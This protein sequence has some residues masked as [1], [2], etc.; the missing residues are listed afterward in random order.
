MATFVLVHGSWHGAWCWRPLERHLRAA[1]HN[2]YAPTLSGCAERFDAADTG[3]TLQSHIGDVARFLFF[4]DLTDVVLV[5]HSSA[6]MI[7]PGVSDLEHA[8]ILSLV[9]LDAYVV[10]PGQRGFDLWTA[11]RIAEARQAVASGNPFRKPFGPDF[12]GITDPGTAEWVRARLTPHPLATYDA[13]VAPESPQAAALPRLYVQCTEGPIA[14]VFVPI[15]EAVRTRCWPTI[16]QPW[17]HDC[18]LTHPRELA[19]LLQAE[20]AGRSQ[21]T[22]PHAATTT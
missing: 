4:E 12:L 3:V 14:P 17:P 11:E 21:T 9:Y 18:M 16:S 8:R 13:P 22:M 10:P 7:L 1:G 19:A 2:V 20:V 15:F 5:G 6:G